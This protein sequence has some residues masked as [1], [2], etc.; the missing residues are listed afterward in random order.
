MEKGFG[1]FLVIVSFFITDTEG[2]NSG[3]Q[4]E[5]PMDM[6]LASR[7]GR[8]TY[9]PLATFNG[10]TLVTQCAFHCLQDAGICQ[11][12]S[13]RQQD[14]LCLLYNIT[15]TSATTMESDDTFMTYDIALWGLDQVSTIYHSSHKYKEVVSGF[16]YQY[17]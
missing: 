2:W 5:I 13:H 15:V 14:S 8:P 16:I 3:F 12:F 7:E 4:W 11:S 9:H 17:T 1:L 6:D 10:T